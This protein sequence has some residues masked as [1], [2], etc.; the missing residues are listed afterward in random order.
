MNRIHRLRPM[1]Q[2]RGLSLAELLVTLA[3]ISVITVIAIPT[4]ATRIERARTSGARADVR[5]LA[6]A[7]EACAAFHG[8]Y[9]PLR[10]LDDLAPDPNLVADRDALDEETLADVALIDPFLRPENQTTQLTL[11]EWSSNRRVRNIYEGWAGPFLDPQ[12]V[13]FGPNPTDQSELM[14]DFVLDPW[15]FPYRWFSAEGIIGTSAQSDNVNL[16]DFDAL[17]TGFDDGQITTNRTNYNNIGRY[18]VMSLGRD[19]E[20]DSNGT[21]DEQ[22]D[23]IWHTFGTDGYETGFNVN[24]PF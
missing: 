18:V 6:Q 3:I 12:R 7:E 22:G 23:D 11:S 19:G 5:A 2:R 17:T 10:V 14:R 20:Y 21:D 15:G 4:V 9:V 16:G 24:F 8:F 13:A 1:L